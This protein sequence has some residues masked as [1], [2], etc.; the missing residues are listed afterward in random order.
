MLKYVT[1]PPIILMTSKHV[2]FKK[3]ADNSLDIDGRPYCNVL[4]SDRKLGQANQIL[5]LHL[6]FEPGSR[7]KRC[8]MGSHLQTIMTL[9][10]SYVDTTSSALGEPPFNVFEIRIFLYL[11]LNYGITDQL[12]CATTTDENT[13]L[14]VHVI[15]SFQDPCQC[16]AVE[17]S[18]DGVFFISRSIVAFF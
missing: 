13:S 5:M 15:Y 11:L 10:H 7:S 9:T 2:K 12:F 16:R 18:L 1:P 17:D 8:Q 4:T 14:Q 3:N 6:A